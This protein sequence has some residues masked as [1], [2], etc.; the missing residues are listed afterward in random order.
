MELYAVEI[1][2]G[3]GSGEVHAIAACCNCAFIGVYG[4]TVYK[5]KMAVLFNPSKQRM[6]WRVAHLVPAHVR[7]RQA[8]IG[9]KIRP[10]VH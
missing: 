2:V 7:Q 8:V 3:N 1:F 5:V 4:V 6:V 10:P 9:D